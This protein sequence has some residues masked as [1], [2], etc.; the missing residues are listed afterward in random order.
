MLRS[1]VGSEMCIRDRGLVV[2]PPEREIAALFVIDDGPYFEIENIDPYGLARDARKY[3]GPYP[4]IAHPPCARWGRLW[5]GGMRWKSAYGERKKLGDDDGCFLWA[6]AYVR[7]YG[8]VIEHPKFSKA[9]E[10]FGITIPPATGGWVTADEYGGI[11]CEVDQ[12]WYGHPA[13][14]L[15]WLYGFGIDPPELARGRG[16]KSDNVIIIQKPKI[17]PKDIDP[18]IPGTGKKALRREMTGTV[19]LSPWDRAATPAPFKQLL[20][21]MVESVDLERN[22]RPAATLFGTFD[23]DPYTETLKIQPPEGVVWDFQNM[24][25]LTA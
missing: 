9:Y 19:G 10:H 21:D 2:R 17:L 13:S 12:R 6:L 3:E 20:I 23:G 4:V 14:K 22:V 11:C 7:K 15:T 24:E 16:P 8:G 5:F 18:L 1:L 25:N